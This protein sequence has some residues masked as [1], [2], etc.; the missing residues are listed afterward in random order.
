MG[1]EMTTPASGPLRSRPGAAI[2]G[3]ARGLAL[4]ALSLV[5]AGLLLALPLGIGQA[6]DA[7]FTSRK[8]YLSGFALG[9]LL[10]PGIIVVLRPLANLTRGLADWWCGVPVAVPY[11]P[12]PGDGKKIGIR[13]RLR[14]LLRDP[15]TWR[16]VAWVAV[17]PGVSW[18]LPL[19]AWATPRLLRGYGLL[20]RSMLRR[21]GRASWPCECAT[22]TRRGP[23]LSTTEPPSCAGSNGTCTTGRRPGW[24]RWE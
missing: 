7:V 14:W 19:A 21:P 16:D 2:T 17:S 1:S 13:G 11:L 15:A 5:N 9:L 24:S 6:V 10:I 23:R 12:P 18:V 4:W 3:W 8:G 22:C 20:A